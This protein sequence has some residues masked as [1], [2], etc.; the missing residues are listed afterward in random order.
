MKRKIE[1]IYD[2][3]RYAMV[4]K[5]LRD[6]E[7]GDIYVDVLDI[8]QI[9]KEEHLRNVSDDNVVLW[10][11]AWI[12]NKVLM[13]VSKLFAMW[14]ILEDDYFKLYENVNLDTLRAKI[15]AYLDNEENQH[16][17]DVYLKVD[18]KEEW[19]YNNIKELYIKHMEDVEEWCE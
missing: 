19:I 16:F 2:N 13:Y 1:I 11:N 15:R 5:Y 8:D 4:D 12:R 3:V 14:D 17:T 9:R 7:L 18:N 10:C 6:R